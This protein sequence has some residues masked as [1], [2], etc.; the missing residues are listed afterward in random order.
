VRLSGSD[1]ILSLEKRQRYIVGN[2]HTGISATER[3]WFGEPLPRSSS[4]PVK[5]FFIW[6]F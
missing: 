3:A 4:W 5:M 2:G 6:R 1:A